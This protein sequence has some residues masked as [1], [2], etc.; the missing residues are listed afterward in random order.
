MNAGTFWIAG[1]GLFAVLTAGAGPSQAMSG[2]EFTYAGRLTDAGLPANG[3]Y[4]MRFALYDAPTAGNM[5][6]PSICR[7]Q[8]VVTD[9]LFLVGLD[10]GVEPFD[11]R[12]LWLEISVRPDGVPSNCDAG[13]YT[14]LAPRQPITAV[15][16]ALLA[17]S[18]Q[19]PLELSGD[20]A[21]N[22]IVSITNSN[23]DGTA[24]RLESTS[25]D[26]VTNY[27]LWCET[28]GQGGR[29][30]LGLASD[31]IGSGVANYGV[32]GQSAGINGRGVYGYATHFSGTNYGVRG[33]T[34]SAN[35]WAGYF[36]GRG[37]FSGR[38][39]VGTSAPGYPLHV[40]GGDQFMQRITSSNTNGTWVDL[41]NTTPGG[42]VWSILSTGSA[43]GEGAG[44]LVLRTP[45]QLAL[46]I[47]TTGY[48]G[49]GD[50]SPAFR[51]ELPNDAGN[52]GRGRANAWTTYS[53][54][55]WKTDIRTLDDALQTVLRLRG[56]RYVWNAEHGGAS[57]IGFVAEEVG[58]VIPEIVAWEEN[59]L[60]AQ[61]LAY[62]R[63]TAV[64]VEAIKEQQQQ[65]A[66]QR[67]QI[68]TQG[69]QI[70]AQAAEL[71]RLGALVDQLR[72]QR[73]E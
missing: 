66:T 40:S 56:V 49:F 32:W 33:K 65:I 50:N 2:T 35:G 29:A 28:H 7:D 26:G 8:V 60:D 37:Y 20:D 43:N 54:R 41:Q 21:L 5:I 10:F 15:P 18:V 45:Q 70:A 9:G 16:Y 71:R 13:G 63:I 11:G 52:G 55:R 73:A 36:E 42:N 39:G 72:A 30:V 22:P 1:A 62:D 61:A 23:L 12:D 69:A 47:D 38:L 58:Q 17:R 67:E 48:V 27:T 57:D 24:L 34:N 19:V 59:G 4:D 46:D 51:I 64:T 14:L 68:A 3:P 25:P 31:S 53:S 44:D 6:D